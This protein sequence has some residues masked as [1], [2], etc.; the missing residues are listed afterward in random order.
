[1]KV[2][3]ITLG[4]LLIAAVVVII[5][6]K[7]KNDVQNEFINLCTQRLKDLDK[8]I[9]TLKSRTKMLAEDNRADNKG[10]F[11]GHH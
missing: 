3:V 2:L 11:Q 1:M 5:R 4:L 6:Q 7:E 9:E 10:E 8:E